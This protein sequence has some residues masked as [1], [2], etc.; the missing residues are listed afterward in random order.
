MVS[1]KVGLWKRVAFVG[2]D[3][4]WVIISRPPLGY[5]LFFQIH[6]SP[7]QIDAV[8]VI[9]SNPVRRHP[10]SKVKNSPTF[11]ALLSPSI[12][13]SASRF[14][15]PSFSRSSCTEDPGPP[16]LARWPSTSFDPARRPYPS[17]HSISS[18]DR[19]GSLSRVR[20]ESFLRS[21]K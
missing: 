5:P 21:L 1:E 17:S 3:V 6:D 18:L 10:S 2:Q 12:S 9:E 8:S 16:L 19:L 15:A 14:A 11:S 20:P 4:P 13:A 7:A